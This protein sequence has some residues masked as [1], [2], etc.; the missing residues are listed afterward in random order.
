MDAMTDDRRN[1]AVSLAQHAVRLEGLFDRRIAGIL[2]AH[3]ISRG[4]LDVLRALASGDPAGARPGELSSRLLLTTGGLS[5]ILRRLQADGLI[6][7]QHDLS[8]ARSHRVQ[9][10]PQGRALAREAG[11][12][13]A[14]AMSDALVSV[15]PSVLRAA[16]Q[17]LHEV[18]VALGEDGAVHLDPTRPAG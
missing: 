13:A 8:D 6:E 5:N 18:L 12:A 17:S 16:A 10:T 4:E 2:H 14:V 11:Q 15:D 3:G 9:L 1:D 7:R